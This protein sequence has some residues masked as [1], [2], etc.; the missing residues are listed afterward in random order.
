M[1]HLVCTQI[2][3]MYKYI[4]FLFVFCSNAELI[5]Q[6]LVPNNSFETFS[7]CPSTYGQIIRATSW[8]NVTSHT[9]TPDYF[10]TCGPAPINTTTAFW[11]PQI[12]ATGNG[13]AG[14]LTYHSSLPSGREYIQTQ[15]TSPLVA[16]QTYT[17][18]LKASLGEICN[19][20]TSLQVY[21]SP[22]PYVMSPAGSTAITAVSPQVVFATVATNKTGWTTLSFNYLATAAHQ[23]III[24]SFR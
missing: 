18:S 23:Y 10:N 6:N 2:N 11:G 13:Y 4:I 7:L 12:P 17:V 1:V 5:S 22:A 16:G 8:T 3:Y 21:L 9:G 14:V 19:F 20:A 15:L 24:G